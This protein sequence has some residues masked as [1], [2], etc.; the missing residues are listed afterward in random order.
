MKDST[1]ECL[2]FTVINVLGSMIPI[3]LFYL[4]LC[5]KKEALLPFSSISDRGDIIIVSI[6]LMIS[7]CYSIY[8]LKKAHG[9]N[10]SIGTIYWITLFFIVMT[11]FTYTLLLSEKQISIIQSTIIQIYSL[12]ILAWSILVVY[13]SEYLTTINPSVQ[14]NRKQQLDKL[15]DKFD[16]LR[17]SMGD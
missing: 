7:A 16:S 9:S 1:H 13:T 17:K 10:G 15:D 6:S 12:I 4:A 14:N 11:T 5:F 8:G 2:K 3:I